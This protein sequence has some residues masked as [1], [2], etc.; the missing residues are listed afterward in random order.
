MDLE[1]FSYKTLLISPRVVNRRC[2]YL[3]EKCKF[4][5]RV[6]VEIVKNGV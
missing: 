1:T 4:G 5:C 2:D 6:R 3:G